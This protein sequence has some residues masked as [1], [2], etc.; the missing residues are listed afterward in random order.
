MILKCRLLPAS[1]CGCGHDTCIEA[2][3]RANVVCHGVSIAATSLPAH[4]KACHAPLPQPFNAHV[5]DPC[6]LVQMYCGFQ[7]S[8]ASGVPRS[9]VT[10]SYFFCN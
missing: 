5:L 8:S 2:A 6:M 3:D 7:K 9:Y 1:P 10:C 4:I